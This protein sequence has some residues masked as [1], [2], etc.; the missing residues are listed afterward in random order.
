MRPEEMNMA[1][2][3]ARSF[4]TAYLLTNS[5]EDAE[6]AVLAGIE[7]WSPDGESDEALFHKVLR[8]AA[9]GRHQ[10][11]PPV[12]TERRL[13]LPE[14]LRVVMTLAP[15]I[16]RCFVLRNLA[17]MSAQACARLLGLLPNQVDEFAG[18]AQRCLA[19]L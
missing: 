16:R 1:N 2:V 18:A 13:W 11:E 9:H 7:A 17:G 8:A 4:R 14:E 15:P 3:V 12:R 6:S 19:T 5:A 10:W